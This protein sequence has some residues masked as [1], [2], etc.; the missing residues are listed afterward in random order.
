MDFIAP[1]EMS[2]ETLEE[3]VRDGLAA[4]LGVSVDHVLKLV[5]SKIQQPGSPRLRRL[6]AGAVMQL[7]IS[8]EVSLPEAVDPEAMVSMVN[9]ITDETTAESQEFRRVMTV[10][11]GVVKI[12]HV[13]S[14][15]AART[16]EDEVVISE[17]P[18]E[19]LTKTTVVDTSGASKWWIVLGIVLVSLLVLGGLVFIGRKI[20]ST[21]RNESIEPKR[22]QWAEEAGICSPTF[23]MAPAPNTLLGSN[24]VA[25]KAAARVDGGGLWQFEE[26]REGTTSDIVVIV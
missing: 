17:A 18:P 2:Q 9:R 25:E 1:N 8:Y 24:G 12:H 21:E 26:G 13:V 23:E 14:K 4:A 11:Y 22:S 19:K 3:M 16:F 10:D 7:Q 6:Q 20:S 5:V 15:I